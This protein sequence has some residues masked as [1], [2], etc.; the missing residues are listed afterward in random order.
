VILVEERKVIRE[1]LVENFLEKVGTK[2]K[3]TEKKMEK[4]SRK[5][6]EK[7]RKINFLKKRKWKIFF[8]V[9]P[10]MLLFLY[11]C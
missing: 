11:Q 5:K 1:K 7:L 6:M 3:E 4:Q 10:N 9:I 2:R 8:K